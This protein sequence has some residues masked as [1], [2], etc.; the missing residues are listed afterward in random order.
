[1]DENAV[2]ERKWK[3]VVNGR[4]RCQRPKLLSTNEGVVNERKCCDRAKVLSTNGGAVTNIGDTIERKCCLSTKDRV[5]NERSC[6]C[7]FGTRTVF[8][9]WRQG[10]NERGG[11]LKFSPFALGWNRYRPWVRGMGP[12]TLR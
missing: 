2:N 4:R 12:K 10:A 8:K 1:M 7:C 3:S 11:A 9:A 6:S 5:V